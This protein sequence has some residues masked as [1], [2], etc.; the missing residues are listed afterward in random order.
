MNKVKIGMILII[1]LISTSA[2]VGCSKKDKG[3]Q[4]ELV[5]EVID[6]QESRHYG[7]EDASNEKTKTKE[8]DRKSVV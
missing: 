5:D 2:F 7:P 6:L 4:N 3:K 1:I 8:A